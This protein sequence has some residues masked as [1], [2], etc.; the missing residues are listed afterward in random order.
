M[1][2]VI[3]KCEFTY[4]QLAKSITKACADAHACTLGSM[5]SPSPR[6][7]ETT[8]RAF[9]NASPARLSTRPRT[10]R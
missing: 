4:I 8:S 6:S 3:A 9:S 2:V 5:N 7:S 1:T 10:S